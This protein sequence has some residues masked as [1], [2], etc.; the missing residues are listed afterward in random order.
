M[1]DRANKQDF[2]RIVAKMLKL[3]PHLEKT[4]KAEM[5]WRS[6]GFPGLHVIMGDVFNPYMVD[7][8]RKAS[9][10]E[11]RRIFRFVEEM[12]CDDS[13]YVSNVAEVTICERIVFEGDWL[14]KEAVVYAHDKTT[15]F[16]WGLYETFNPGERPAH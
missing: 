11:K 16:L 12:A 15:H 3:F 4:Y 10:E 6:S 8:L 1:N 5:E 2:K 9:E 13:N 14:F 7:A